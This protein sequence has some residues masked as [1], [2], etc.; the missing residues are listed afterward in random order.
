MVINTVQI[1]NIFA[2]RIQR[3]QFEFYCDYGGSECGEQTR[4]W[5]WGNG[6]RATPVAISVDDVSILVE[7]GPEVQAAPDCNAGGNTK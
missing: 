5:P 4:K 7:E 2:F 1:M 6:S 3:D